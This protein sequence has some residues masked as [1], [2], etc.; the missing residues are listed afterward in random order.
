MLFERLK[1]YSKENLVKANINMY[2]MCQ[3][4]SGVRL[5]CQTD[6]GA[7]RPAIGQP[8]GGSLIGSRIPRLGRSGYYCCHEAT[9]E[10]EGRDTLE[11]SP[12]R[13]GLGHTFRNWGRESLGCYSGARGP[14]TSCVSWFMY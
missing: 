7:G 10:T 14:R 8:Q 11:G 12:R 9:P 13:A 4:R 5:G 3:D 6:E 2:T 1:L